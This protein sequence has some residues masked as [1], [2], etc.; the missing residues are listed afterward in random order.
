[1]A[2]ARASALADVT[3]GPRSGPGVEARVV[4][5]SDAGNHEHAAALA[6]EAPEEMRTHLLTAAY[7]AW[8][9]REPEVALDAA[10]MLDDPVRRRVAFHAA[11]SGWAKA[12]PRALAECAL[13]FPE[14]PERSFAIVAAVRAWRR[15]D[16]GEVGRWL[17]AHP[18][19]LAGARERALIAED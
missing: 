4:A 12:D 3:T 8:A 11:A 13:A 9:Q 5:A 19:A 18:Q 7:H 14:G 10:L 2:E 17:T 1:M 6:A 16:A 15:R